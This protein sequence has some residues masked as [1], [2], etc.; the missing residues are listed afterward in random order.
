MGFELWKEDLW[1][2]PMWMPGILI[3]LLGCILLG[4]T[5]AGRWGLL[6]LAAPECRFDRPIERLRRLAVFGLFQRKQVR[7][8]SSGIIHLFIFFPF[9]F[10][11]P[12]VTLLALLGIPPMSSPAGA[13]WSAYSRLCDVAATLIFAACLSAAFLRTCLRPKRFDSGR[14]PGAL[15]ILG[16]ISVLVLSDS[17][18]S[19]A[20]AQGESLWPWTLAY[21]FSRLVAG[22]STEQVRSFGM[23]AWLV[24]AL[25]FFGFLCAV[26]PRSKQFHEMTGLLN[27]FCM[28][29][30]KGNVKPL[31]FGMSD[32]ELESLE[33]V[34]AR[35]LKDFTWKHIL[36]FYSCADC[37]RC[38]DQCPATAAGRALS[39]R[40]FTHEAQKLSYAGRDVPLPFSEE[41]IWSCTTC[42][43]CEEEC[44]LGI[45][46]IDKIVDL[47][48][49]A[50][51]DGIVP[52]NIA[53]ALEGLQKRGNPW[54]LAPAAAW[55]AGSEE[56]SSLKGT[57]ATGTL[58]FP[59]SFT[60][61]DERAR[62]IADAVCSVLRHAGVSFGIPKSPL[63]DSGHE[64]R[65]LGEEFLFMEL[66]DANEKAI[67]ASGALLIVTAD[68]HALNAL[69][70]DYRNMPKAVHISEFIAEA[71]DAGT[72]RLKPADD[73]RV[74]V[75]HD[76]CYLGRH[77]E[78][79]SAPRRVLH[80]V[81]GLTIR[82]MVKSRDRALCCGGPLSFFHE[83]A[84]S[85]R[86]ADLRLDCALDAGAEVIVTACPYCLVNLTEAAAS[87][88]LGIEIIDLV[89]LVSRR[90]EAVRETI[91]E[92][93]VSGKT[94][95][96]SE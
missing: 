51:E 36:D 32:V 91:P 73:S 20:T 30:G 17:C 95:L 50:E 44:P 61:F 52:P 60:T 70:R 49:A 1:G 74:H 28:R 63:R 86:P 6:R 55:P 87:R 57:S 83:P 48:R 59:D 62:N 35:R 75:F 4:A 12:H 66:R 10:T 16:I 37:G 72:I 39:P 93:E 31:R 15:A 24:H 9:L 8:P 11:V 78:I 41:A 13:A 53:K 77:N 26:L 94:N 27:L 46:Y 96:I 38:T 90:I 58:F 65:R 84:Q 80:A 2:L 34:G 45:E 3:P 7:Y 23:F 47:R 92:M 68:P 29:L 69:R 14:M 54:G 89:E 40:D 19:A 21:G 88:G 42:G 79:Y 43:A 5:L 76:P 71:L 82:E 33:E 22:S 81:S 67:R 64:A 18:W 56:A 85:R 25:F